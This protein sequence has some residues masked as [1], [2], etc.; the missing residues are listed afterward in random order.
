MIG[1]IKKCWLQHERQFNLSSRERRVEGV[2]DDLVQM[3]RLLYTAPSSNQIL[4]IQ[5]EFEIRETGYKRSIK[6]IRAG[7]V[8]QA[9]CMYV[10]FGW[11]L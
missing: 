10:T 1:R 3:R 11:Y 8:K 4:Q 7:T 9:A 5:I 2:C 6:K